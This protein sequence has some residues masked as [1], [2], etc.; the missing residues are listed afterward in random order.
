MHTVNHLEK[1]G[2]T[3]TYLDVDEN[4]FIDPEDVKNAINEK[5]AL[6]TIMYANNEIGTIQEISEIGKICKEKGV[7]FHTDAVQAVGHLEID[8]KKQNI[9][10]LSLSAHKFHGPKGVGALYAKK[11]IK[12]LNLMQGGGQESNKRPGTENVAGIIGLAK[13]LELSM[14]IEKKEMIF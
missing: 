8:V 11:G 1:E 5:T 13:A 2:F 12:L 6:V 4:G 14:K 9:D 7:I 3:A 10:L